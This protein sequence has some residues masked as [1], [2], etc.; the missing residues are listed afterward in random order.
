MAT[1]P[2]TATHTERGHPIILPTTDANGTVKS[3]ALAVNDLKFAYS[4]I[5]AAD[6]PPVLEHVTLNLPRGAR[7]ILVGANGA[8]KL[9][10][11]KMEIRMEIE[12]FFLL[13]FFVRWSIH[14]LFC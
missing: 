3:L 8:G 9:A 7:C 1:I 2:A 13:I 10:I 4:Q 6:L 5:A 12:I 11:F 14:V